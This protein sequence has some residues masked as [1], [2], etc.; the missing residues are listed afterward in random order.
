GAISEKGTVQQK[1]EELANALTKPEN[2]R[3]YR[4]LV[5]RLWAQL[6]G[7]GIVSP[8]DEMDKA[9][10][11]Q[12]L[13][14]WMAVYFVEQGYDIKQILYLITTSK[15]YQLPSIAVKDPATVN[16]DK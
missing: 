15:T 14:D 9:P 11:S 7:R 13:L 10:W 4:T 3:L 8:T 1:S 16:T 6:M 12:D 2:G 5:N